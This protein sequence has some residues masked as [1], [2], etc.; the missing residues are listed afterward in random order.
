MGLGDEDPVICQVAQAANY[1]TMLGTRN[2]VCTQ[3]SMYDSRTRKSSKTLQVVVPGACYLEM[4]VAG[5]T[6]FVGRGLTALVV[7][8]KAAL[9]DSP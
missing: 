3:S 5:C 6:T 9:Q 7:D 4:I 2:P 1:S 8:A